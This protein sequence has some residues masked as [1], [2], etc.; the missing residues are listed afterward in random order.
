M[1]SRFSAR[2]DF[3]FVAGISPGRHLLSWEAIF[4]RG[5]LILHSLEA[6]VA[7][8]GVS[9]QTS[10]STSR[11]TSRQTTDSGRPTLT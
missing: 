9:G 11:V 7:A 8:Q 2:E 3:R 4:N 5:N 10:G 6:E 1:S